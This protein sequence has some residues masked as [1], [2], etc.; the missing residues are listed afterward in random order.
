VR[1]IAILAFA[2]IGAVTLPAT[3][4]LQIYIAKSECRLFF[5]ADGELVKDYPCATG[6]GMCTPVR[7]WVIANKRSNGG[8]TY[9]DGQWVYTGGAAIPML[10][11]LWMGLSTSSGGGTNYGIHGNRDASS[12][13]HMRSHG[14][15]RMH[16]YHIDELYGIADAG[17]RVQTVN[18]LSDLTGSL[19]ALRVFPVAF[20]ARTG[21]TG[22]DLF[23][24]NSAGQG[25]RQLTRLPGDERTPVFSPDGA[26]IAFVHSGAGETVLSLLEPGSSTSREFRGVFASLCKGWGDDGLV[27]TDATGATRTFDPTTG[28]VAPAAAIVGPVVSSDGQRIQV[29]GPKGKPVEIRAEAIRPKLPS[30]A[31]IEGVSLSSDRKRLAFSALVGKQRDIFLCRADG[32]LLRN[33]TESPIDEV[34]PAWSPVPVAASAQ[35]R[36]MLRPTTLSVKTDPP[37]LE[38]RVRPPGA[39]EAYLKGKSPA[40]VTIHE[41]VPGGA[42]YEILVRD[43]AS[44]LTASTSVRLAEGEHRSVDLSI[45]E[46]AEAEDGTEPSAPP[47]PTQP[48]DSGDRAVRDL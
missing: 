40:E 6:A 22:Y 28:K 26:S 36:P 11:P 15:I 20:A 29:S 7:S 32:G 12:I 17:T 4:G 35:A 24:T 39:R 34:D 41:P 23:L 30:A 33:I 47:A 21:S 9:R 43:P 8:W 31:R 18:Y 10:G 38:I 46:G 2:L 5:A 1:R 14:C 27:F 13:G 45:E 44:G 25:R 37:G 3:A 16:N 19:A 48:D 42:D